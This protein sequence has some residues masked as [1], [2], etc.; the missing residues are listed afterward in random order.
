VEQNVDYSNYSDSRDL[1]VYLEVEEAILAGAS[2]GGTMAI[3]L[4]L[5]HPEL[6]QALVRVGSGLGGYEFTNQGFEQEIEALCKA[7]SKGDKALSA[8]Y[9][10]RIWIDGQGRASESVSAPFRDKALEMIIHTLELPDE[11][12]DV[13]ELEPQAIDRLD[14]IEQPLLVILGE[15]DRQDIFD[16]SLLLCSSVPQAELLIIDDAAHLPN[17]EKLD[18]FNQIVFDFLEAQLAE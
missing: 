6:V 4:A 11:G 1:L 9:S 13:H 15:Y 18:E 5:E 10:A 17:M 8:E 16:I 14:E 7:Y 2:F 12:G 3:D